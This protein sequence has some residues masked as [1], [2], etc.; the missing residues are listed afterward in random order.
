MLDLIDSL[1]NIT[2]TAGQWSKALPAGHYVGLLVR[3]TGTAAASRDESHIG[4]LR[5]TYESP[6]YTGDI[7]S[8]SF[9]NLRKYNRVQGGII[10]NTTGTTFALSAVLPFTHFGQ[11]NSLYVGVSERARLWMNPCSAAMTSLTVDIYGLRTETV[12][13][14][15][16]PLL[17][18]RRFN[19]LGGIQAEELRVPNLLALMLTDASTTNPTSIV[20]SAR[21]KPAR[22]FDLGALKAFTDWAFDVESSTLGVGVL[23]FVSGDIADTLGDEYLIRFSG[24]SGYLDFITVSAHIM[25]GLRNLSRNVVQSAITAA[26]RQ[27][28]VAPVDSAIPAPGINAELLARETV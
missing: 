8:I 6:E 13:A 26:W 24:G 10:E 19:N 1:T 20:V 18:Q 23:S 15:Y 3:A 27:A 5:L 22:M 12:P 21:T 14:N 9:A 25:P 2:T 17:F 28:E 4:D 11:P 7:L 16:L